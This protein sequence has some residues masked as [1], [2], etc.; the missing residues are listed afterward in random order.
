MVTASSDNSI[1]LVKRLTEIAAGLSGYNADDLD[2][3]STFLELGFDSLFLTQLATAFQKEFGLKITFRQLIAEQPTL[4]QLGAYIFA[5]GPEIEMPPDA[6][7][8]T[9]AGPDELEDAGS[10]STE[11]AESYS[12]NAEPAAHSTAEVSE[13]TAIFT[14]QLELMRDQLEVIRARKKGS[15]T[16][17][18]ASVL[19]TTPKVVKQSTQ[20]DPP[21]EM[22]KGFAPAIQP[23]TVSART[24]DPQV[25][26]HVDRL[27][28]RYN[29]KTRQSKEQ[30]QIDRACHA[31]P[32]TAAGFNLLWKEAV[33]PIVVKRSNGAYLWD[34]DGNQYIDLLNGFGPNFFGH[35]APF[36][37]EAL[38]SQL[39]D[40]FEIG[41]QTPNAGDAARLM[42]ELTGMDRVSWVNTGSEAVQA[43]IRIARTVTGRE[44]IVVFKGSYHGNFDEVLVRGVATPDGEQK[45]LPLAP[46]IP[47][48]SVE[49]V[50]VLDYGEQSALDAIAASADEIAAVL[51]EPVQSRRPDFQPTEFLQKIRSL[52]TAE[53]II[54]VFD[55]VITGFRTCPGGAQE[56]FGIEAD[57]ATYGKVIGGGMPIGAVAGRQQFM[58]TFDGGAWCYGDASQPT[59]GVTFFA[60]T[61]VRHPLAIAGAHA[62]LKYLKEQGPALQNGINAKAERLAR[63]LNA[64]FD[65]RGVAF[66]VAQFASQMFIRNNEPGDLPTLFFYHMRDRGIHVLEDFPCY[67][68]A[69]HSDDDVDAIIAAAK[70]S[71]LEMQ[72]DGLLP[73]PADVSTPIDPIIRK[74]PMTAGQRT[75]WATS[76]LSDQASCAFNESDSFHIE[77]ALDPDLFAQAFDEA[78]AHHEAFRLRFDDAGEFQYLAD[79][80]DIALDF[81]DL[82]HLADE[83]RSVRIDEVTSCFAMTPFDLEAGPLAKAALFK[84]GPQAFI[85][86]FYAHHLIFDGYSSDLLIRELVA[87]YEAI[88]TGSPARLIKT[89]PFSAYVAKSIAVEGVPAYWSDIYSDGGPLPAD[90]R[91]DKPR[92]ERFSYRGATVRRVV[93]KSATTALRDCASRRG[94]SMSVLSMAVYA[95]MLSRLARNEDIVV[96]LPMAGQAR[97][98]IETVGYCV[99][100]LPI[101]VKTEKAQCFNDFVKDIQDK[102][103]DAFDHQ[104]L[105]LTALINNGDVPRSPAR[106]P[107][108]EAV[109]NFSGYFSGLEAA[110]IR[111]SARENRRRSVCHEMFFNLADAGETMIIDVDYASDVYEPQTVNQWI[112]VFIET[113]QDVANNSKRTLGELRREFASDRIDT[114]DVRKLEND[115]PPTQNNKTAPAPATPN[116]QTLLQAVSDVF[117]IEP[118]SMEV[119]FFELGGHSIHASRLLTKLRKQLSPSLRIRAIFETATLR[120]LAAHIDSLSTPSGGDDDRDEFV[121]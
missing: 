3:E 41:P 103:L 45:T 62:S 75:I 110:G 14:R 56:Y 101:R 27:I 28:A 67:M 30:T 24:L 46:G 12:D 81:E 43:A 118:P 109:F 84:T 107:L 59:A 92:P 104:D 49:N 108:V 8:C 33:Y 71:I 10:T 4:A 64:F 9:D 94:V 21:L 23:N 68:T 39:D 17:P 70:S 66:K 93:S 44:K 63:E 47:F 51:V 55:E 114:V 22:P 11:Q 99:N 87:R 40:G 74:I 61:F 79:A 2:P 105:S 102:Y 115:E 29:A 32:R 35:R 100:I 26:A 85:F 48:G 53:E 91:T 88:Q 89:E 76:Q 20:P 80:P 90:L 15:V 65:E 16:P 97:H 5:Q 38:R 36:I 111:L 119:N 116:E 58:D 120:E 25:K 60:G 73:C 78:M 19:K 82:T 34:L 98:G 96:G 113:L 50:I 37:T 69:A 117:G 42:C 13:L 52:T 106:V 83:V 112:D 95:V 86:V 54:L 57:L 6:N 1:H 121:F 77:G 72:A 7:D 18:G 31:D